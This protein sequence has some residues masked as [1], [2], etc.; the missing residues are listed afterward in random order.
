M[1][2]ILTLGRLNPRISKMLLSPAVRYVLGVIFPVFALAIGLSFY[3]GYSDLAA[4]S[5]L[6]S[7]FLVYQLSANLYHRFWSHRQFD[8]SPN[9]AKVTS[10]LGLFAMTGDPLSFAWTHRWHHMHADT[11]LDVHSP[12]HGKFHS[13]FGWLFKKSPI[14]GPIID[15]LFRPEYR[16]LLSLSKYKIAIVWVTLI[17]FA[18]ISLKILLGILLA[19]CCALVLELIANTF[20]H[21]AE[22]KQARNVKI[23]AWLAMGSYHYDHHKNAKNIEANDPGY[24]LIQSLKFLNLAK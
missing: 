14:N 11:D 20:A 9:F 2:A 8:L 17:L 22:K 24:L 3:L 6:I 13:F 10:F 18:F 4:V 1:A 23:L 19:M 12:I 7:F 21:S 16:Y 15:D 5:F